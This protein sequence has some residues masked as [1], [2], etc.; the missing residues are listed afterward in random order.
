MQG[1]PSVMESSPNEIPGVPLPAWTKR[2][3]RETKTRR[4]KV[5]SFNMA[6]LNSQGKR[7][8]AGSFLE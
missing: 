6:N 1:R 4:D 3:N 2:R 8:I 7:S 5:Q